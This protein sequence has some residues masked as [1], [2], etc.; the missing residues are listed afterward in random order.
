MGHFFGYRNHSVVQVNESPPYGE[1]ET[2]RMFTNTVYV[3]ARAIAHGYS[4]RFRGFFFDT[5]RSGR[6]DHDQPEI[7]SH[8]R[9]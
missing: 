9:A 8:L 1:I 3:S 2:N 4:S 5:V 6:H 7:C